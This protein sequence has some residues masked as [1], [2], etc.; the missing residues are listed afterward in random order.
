MSVLAVRVIGENVVL[1][2][3]NLKQ[4][5]ILYTC[6]QVKPQSLTADMIADA[7][8]LLGIKALVQG[9]A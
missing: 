4:N 2:C 5:H 8:L 3:P 6:R 9:F 1:S 7:L